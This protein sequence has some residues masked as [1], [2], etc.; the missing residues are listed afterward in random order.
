MSTLLQQLEGR[1][2]A[3]SEGMRARLSVSTAAALL[4]TRD[5]KFAA[6]QRSLTQPKPQPEHG[7]N[8]SFAA[9]STRTP[10]PNKKP[11]RVQCRGGAFE[12]LPLSG[13]RGGEKVLQNTTGGG[14]SGFKRP[15]FTDHSSEVPQCRDGT[16]KKRCFET[17]GSRRSAFH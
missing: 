10:C 7:R 1:H 12:K 8:H 4:R 16:G 15:H 6:L 2:N 13:G 5:P 14:H 9:S 3:A 11:P 17:L